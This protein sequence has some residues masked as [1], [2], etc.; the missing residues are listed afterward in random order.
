MPRNGLTGGTGDVN[1]QWMTAYITTPGV[2]NQVAA[3]MV[4]L[5][6]QR[7]P[8]G[9][10]SQVIEVLQVEY[11]V[12]H[13]EDGKHAAVGIT[14]QNVT[15]VINYADPAAIHCAKICVDGAAQ[16]TLQFDLTDGAGH[17]VLV[18]TDNIYV[19]GTYSDTDVINIYFRILYRFKNVGLKEYIGITQSQMN[20]V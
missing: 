8:H 15:S 16:T 6:V 5:P 1:P 13:S 12:N 2:S 9:N 3:S 11:I 18:G 4:R 10:K 7:L 17:G 14:T 20:L 19:W